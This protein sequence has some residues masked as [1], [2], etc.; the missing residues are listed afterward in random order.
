MGNGLTAYTAVAPND[1][2]LCHTTGVTAISEPVSGTTMGLMMM[3][4]TLQYQA[5]YMNPTY[6]NAA[7]QMGKAAFVQSGGQAFQDKAVLYAN[8]RAKEAVQAIGVDGKKVAIILTAAKVVR[9]RQIDFKGP[10]IGPV[11]SNLTIN[12]NTGTM[13]L[14]YEW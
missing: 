8:N 3:L 10:N 7:G 9:D 12:P 1:S 11:K 2:Y 4:S 6:S 14:K 13:G 5:P